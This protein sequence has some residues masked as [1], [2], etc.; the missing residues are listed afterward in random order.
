M[1]KLRAIQYFNRA[2]EDGSFTAAARSLDVSTPAVTQLIAA[3]ERE[4]GILLFHRTNRG[5]SLTADGQ[6]Y[7]ETSRK[8]AA[9]LHDLEQR[10]APRA[11]K[12]RGTLTVG[13]R[14]V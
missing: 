9:D 1:D 8:I 6:R 11:V 3:L 14:A 5:L 2:V 4:V 12:P 13:M 10:L 7:Y